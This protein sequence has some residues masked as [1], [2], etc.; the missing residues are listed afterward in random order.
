MPSQVLEEL[1]RL[2]GGTSAAPARAAQLPPLTREPTVSVQGYGDLRLPMTRPQVRM[3]LEAG[4][5]APFGQGERTLV[6]TAVRHTWHFP[7]AHVD[8]DWH[9]Q[10]DA[11]LEHARSALTLPVHARLRAEFHSLLVYEVGQFFAPHQD[12]EKD[13][14]MVATLVVVLPCPFQGGE[15]VVHGDDGELAFPG[16][17]TETS[18]VVF[19]ADALH[20][21]RPVRTGHRVSLTYNLMLEG[22]TSPAGV[23]HDEVADA[24]TL[25][26]RYFTTAIPDRYGR[27]ATVPTRLAY[28]LDHAY[29][30]RALAQGTG[31]LKGVDAQRAAILTEAA[32]RADC[33]V[34]P[35]LA[36]VH[37]TR[38][39]EPYGRYGSGDDWLVTDDTTITHWLTPRGA[40]QE[41]SLGVDADEL[42]ASTP[43]R[44]LR[45][46]HVEREGYMGNYGNTVDRW[47][48]RGA[49]LVWPT[50]LGFANRARVSPEG[51]LREAMLRL[52]G[53][54]V[55]REEAREAARESV[56][57]DLWG[58]METWP[59]LVGHRALARGTDGGVVAMMALELGRFL[60][61]DDLTDRLAD[62]F[63]LEA[64]T[65]ISAESV[66]ALAAERGTDWAVDVVGRWIARD[67]EWAP[68][69][70]R[71]DWVV[72]LPKVVAELSAEPA[73]VRAVLEPAQRWVLARLRDAAEGPRTSRTRTGLVRQA[74]PLAALLRAIAAAPDAAGVRA[75]GEAASMLDDVLTE[76]SRPEALDAAVAV[77]KASRK[78]RDAEREAARI[79]WL[80]EAVTRHLKERLEA[81]P[82]SSDD[83]SITPP[84]GCGCELC[85]T[86]AG[87][88]SDPSAKRL[89]WPIKKDHRQHVHQR[90]DAAELPVTHVTVRVGSPFTLVLTKTADVFAR[91]DRDRTE[92]AKLLAEL[93]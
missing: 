90:I 26:T 30:P 66:V 10:L 4:E 15:L 88:L 8:V 22:S 87:F 37:E 55:D 29:T 69:P 50:R 24:V 89:E 60:G 36:D 72:T 9:G 85:A 71:G 23:A 59:T 52:V 42:A 20:E 75:G 35:A 53:P 63:A 83:W 56:L 11:V 82:R 32:R 6:D 34:V 44:S 80:H 14:A 92:A 91:A 77:V 57:R 43:T 25:L 1:A 21:V 61:D 76:C 41:V 16:S 13:D 47:Y 40:V 70:H 38:N 79:P 48:H 3:L 65:P 31:R 62:P 51:A 27:P 64:L 81:P 19:Y 58:L 49:L 46:Y 17:R 28:L 74:K 68:L 33:D 67:R 84:P 39:D 2:L 54:D 18:M 5:P 12:S 45:A 7:N 86:L 78:W 93:G 73:L